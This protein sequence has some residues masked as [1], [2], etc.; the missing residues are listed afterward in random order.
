MIGFLPT[1]SATT[2]QNR[3]PANL[4]A[5]YDAPV[6]THIHQHALFKPW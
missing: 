5:M 1:R 4:P 3:D 6:H 2:P